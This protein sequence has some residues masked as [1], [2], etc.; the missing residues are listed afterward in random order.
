IDPDLDALLSTRPALPI[1]AYSAAVAVDVL[2]ARHR[3][4]ARLKAT[5]V[6]VL[7]AAPG[8]LPAACVSAYLRLKARARL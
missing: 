3:A 6:S 2:E 8:A 4:A 7:E 5:G 1:D